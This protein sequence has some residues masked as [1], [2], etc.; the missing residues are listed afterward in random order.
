MNK[1]SPYPLS[2]R[3]SYWFDNRMSQGLWPKVRLLL[4]T[5]LVFI[6]VIGGIAAVAKGIESAGDTLLKT[7]M[8]TLGKGGP[9]TL[10]DDAAS[11][12][13]FAM[14][15]LTILYCMFFSACLI[16]LINNALRSKVDEL[17]KG[18]TRV[19]ENDHILILGFNEATLVLIGEFIE[20]CANL[21]KPQTIVILD[22]KS[23]T[24][25]ADAIRR[26]YGGPHDHPNTRI[27]CR[28]GSIFSFPDLERC[29]IAT[30]HSVIVNG[31]SDFESVKSIMA[32]SHILANSAQ[33]N[34][35]QDDQP[36][37]VSVVHGGENA[38]EA[39]IA[40]Q[41]VG[42]ASQLEFLSLNETL[43]RIMVHTSRQ[44][45]LSHVFTELLNYSGHELYLVCDD[46][47]FQLFYGKSIE[48]INRMLKDA[49]AVGVR[50][51]D[52]KVS[53]TDPRKTYFNEGDSLI[54][55]Q[56]DDDKLVTTDKPIMPKHYTQGTANNKQEV[57]ALVI[58]AKPILD[59][60]LVEYGEY[61]YPGSTIHV[62]DPCFFTG[63][64]INPMTFEF[65]ESQGI[66]IECHAANL[67]E[68]DSV[69]E[70]L[71]LCQPDC[72]LVL[73]TNETG[74]DQDDERNIRLLIYLREYRIKTGSSFSITSEIHSGPNKE[75]AMA[76]GTD[77]FIIGSHISALLMAQ[78]SQQREI[79]K[80]F[81]NIL[82]SE[83]F[84]V[85]IK[86]ASWY[87]EP[88]EPVDLFTVSHA[89]A[90]R[91]EIFIGIRQKENGVYQPAVINPSRYVSDMLTL[92]QYT[93]SKD[94]YFVVLA[95]D[96]LYR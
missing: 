27:I 95:E 49:C 13:Y 4:V 86:H 5:T 74:N 2:E 30:S 94:D 28:T 18:Q 15:F 25:M 23:R 11:P 6:L 45:G 47:S 21:S 24:E 37:I 64:P 52:G 75:L 31:D 60:V 67:E 53:I 44:P 29:S 38:V 82:S 9:L 40:A 20:A 70:L 84:E 62:A 65:L 61:L 57:S 72:V 63:N 32:C 22:E 55:V 59:L 17:G 39:T 43:A 19:L 16:G 54:T 35:D 93:F 90:A 92:R 8:Y 26:K 66:N 76:T 48:E 73:A 3:L 71:E 56:E 87:I 36:F 83:G 69:H 78:I 79:S 85:Y 96:G 33:T 77:D 12:L 58:G 80:V 50:T 88:G 51:S 41:N 91:G 14:M 1:K 10:K 7:F 46:P 81:E 89:V 34:P 42:E 68:H